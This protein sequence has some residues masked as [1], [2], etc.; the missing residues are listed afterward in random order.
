MS[1]FNLTGAIA[2]VANVTAT[3]Q[4]MNTDSYDDH[5]VANPR[6]IASTTT[7]VRCSFQPVTGQQLK[8]AKLA[9][10]ASE[11]RS[12]WSPVELR[13]RDRLT[14][15]GV[16]YEVEHVDPWDDTGAYSKAIARKLAPQEPNA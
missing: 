7:G 13:L 4:R 9:F 15:A 2:A 6:T 1:V 5:G 12:V 11:G 10:E 8:R 16:V 3:I 14:V